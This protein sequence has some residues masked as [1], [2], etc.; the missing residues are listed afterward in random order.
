MTMTSEWCGRITGE[1]G[2]EPTE[3]LW[4]HRLLGVNVEGVEE[5]WRRGELGRGELVQHC[6]EEGLD[7]AGRHR[8][9]STERA[10]RAIE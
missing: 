8:H 1:L 2:T 7:A 3:H 9:A 4:R 5:D 6:P 10:Q